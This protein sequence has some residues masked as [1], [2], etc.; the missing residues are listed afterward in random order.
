[1]FRSVP[2]AIDQEAFQEAPRFFPRH[3]SVADRRQLQGE[4]IQEDAVAASRADGSSPPAAPSSSA[5][6]HVPSSGRSGHT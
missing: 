3:W 2:D 6:G 1:M 5:Q 4:T